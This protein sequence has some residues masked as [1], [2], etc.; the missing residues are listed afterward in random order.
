M[1]TVK[2]ESQ[3]PCS[4]LV[5]PYVPQ[6]FLS[7][8]SEEALEGIVVVLIKGCVNQGVEEGIGVPKPQEYA[9]PDWWQ[10]TGTERAD[11]LRQEERNPTQHKHA[12]QD[13]HHHGCPLLLLLPP[14]VSARLEGH[15][16]SAACCEHHLSLLRHLL[17]LGTKEIWNQ[18]N[19][20][21]GNSEQEES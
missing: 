7:L 21:R 15:C 16:G 14:R 12:D 3:T 18:N 19:R 17:R 13:P 8:L 5:F 2:Q 6:P 4:S 1:P 10:A 9:F 20:T 11:E